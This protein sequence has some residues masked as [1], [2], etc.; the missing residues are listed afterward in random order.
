MQNKLKVTIINI[1]KY[2]KNVIVDHT[3]CKGI[4]TRNTNLVDCD[5]DNSIFNNYE[6]NRFDNNYD[7]KQS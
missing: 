6:M 2:Q 1:I 3:L 5:D 4:N 7:E